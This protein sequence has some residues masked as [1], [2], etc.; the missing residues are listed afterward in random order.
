M[1]KEIVSLK[2]E[3]NKLLYSQGTILLETAYADPTDQLSKVLSDLYFR[4][5]ELLQVKE[6]LRK[7]KKQT[8]I[9]R[10]AGHKSRALVQ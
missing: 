9:F 1:E 7:Y 4:D 2:E 8:E 6:D 3:N 5:V 10:Q